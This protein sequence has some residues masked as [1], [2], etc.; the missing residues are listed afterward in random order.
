MVQKGPFGWAA[1][2]AAVA[3]ILRL[4]SLLSAVDLRAMRC[5]SR[6]FRT[7]CRPLLLA[8]PSLPDFWAESFNF[9]KLSRNFGPPPCSSRGCQAIWNSSSLFLILEM[10]QGQIN[11][12]LGELQG[13]PG[14]VRHG[15]PPGMRGGG[16]S[17]SRRGHAARP[18]EDPE[19]SVTGLLGE[20]ERPIS[21]RHLVF[22]WVRAG[23]SV[24]NYLSAI[25]CCRWP[26]GFRSVSALAAC[27]GPASFRGPGATGWKATSWPGLLLVASPC[28]ARRRRNHLSYLRESA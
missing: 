15:R 2:S 23:C 3:D 16:A 25:A 17:P 8:S 11:L 24:W 1:P 27:P 6:S 21:G 14:R 18:Q 26:I 12:L 28:P 7:R 5:K 10:L 13:W 9:F 4:V 22:S 20:T 19:P